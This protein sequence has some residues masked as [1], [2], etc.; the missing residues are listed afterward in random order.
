MHKFNIANISLN[1][2]DKIAIIPNKIKRSNF[3][4]F[5]KVGNGIK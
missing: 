3:D 5:D 4:Y 1:K 2:S